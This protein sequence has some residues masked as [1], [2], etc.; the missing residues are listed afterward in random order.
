M[1]KKKIKSLVKEIESLK[2]TIAEINDKLE[3]LQAG[4]RVLN[5]R[6]FEQEANVVGI[7]RELHHNTSYDD[8][9]TKQELE[10]GLETLNNYILK[11]EIALNKLKRSSTSGE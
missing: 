3:L 6:L 2:S 7:K 9:A 1:G 4:D 11:Q 8:F 10:T 5:R